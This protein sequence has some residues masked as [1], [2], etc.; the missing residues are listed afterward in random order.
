MK[1]I[2]PYYGW[3]LL[4]CLPFNLWAIDKSIVPEQ[5]KIAVTKLEIVN[6]SV[7]SLPKIKSAYLTDIVNTELLALGYQVQERH[8]LKTLIKEQ[9]FSQS[10]VR[11]EDIPALAKLN[12][13]EQIFLGSLSIEN[14]TKESCTEYQIRFGGKILDVATAEYLVI[15]DVL[16]ENSD[17]FKGLIVAI[18]SYFVKIRKTYPIQDTKELTVALESGQSKIIMDNLVAEQNKI[19]LAEIQLSDNFG[20]PNDNIMQFLQTNINTGLMA[21]GYRVMERKGIV[22]LFREQEF[23]QTYVRED[24]INSL[25]NL[26]GIDKV[27]LLSISAF[28]N[29]AGK[30]QYIFST[31]K[32]LDVAS[33]K[34]EMAGYVITDNDGQEVVPDKKVI[35]IFFHNLS[36]FATAKQNNLKFYAK[37]QGDITGKKVAVVGDDA[38]QHD[39]TIDNVAKELLKAGYRTFARS[40][41]DIEAIQEEWQI[42]QEYVEEGQI[43]SP[44]KLAGLDNV[45]IVSSSDL[46]GQGCGS[47][48]TAKLLDQTGEIEWI[49]SVIAP[50]KELAVEIFFDDN[51]TAKPEY[52]LPRSCY[53]SAALLKE[54]TQKPQTPKKFPRKPLA[55]DGKNYFGIQIG[56]LGGTFGTGDYQDGSHSIAKAAK[57][58]RWLTAI[59]ISYVHGINDK[60]SIG[61]LFGGRINYAVGDSLEYSGPYYK[62][63]RSYYS[64]FDGERYYEHNFID[65]KVN[66]GFHLGPK[67]DFYFWFNGGGGFSI[68]PYFVYSLIHESLSGA[69][70][71]RVD[72]SSKKVGSF[73]QDPIL[74]IGGGLRLEFLVGFDDSFLWG[75]D[76]LWGFSLGIEVLGG[77]TPI[78][79]QSDDGKIDVKARLDNVGV[80]IYL[81][82]LNLYFKTN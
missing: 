54:I 20:K 4:I 56:E 33:G 52:S 63:E 35:D 72:Y 45:F 28:V 48:F 24:D 47:V 66:L 12:G 5:H 80:S 78:S 11:E 17:F 65:S 46:A 34:Y 30:Y 27:F 2:L 61:F 19:A 3:L 32:I 74:G 41:L 81:G 58:S 29:L 26:L 7:C 43:I 9:E 73:T 67:I 39:F 70:E 31:A 13:V 75:D 49:G 59:G 25:A 8:A 38:S 44:F 1:F 57:Y 42:S 50:S 62:F 60:I 55:L 21:T 23:S 71:E 22:S 69:V 79:Y 77:A 82:L 53:G 6:N 76:F 36:G 18:Q 40:N 10:Y 15:E 51:F 14:K 37:K 64:A 16:V 68:S